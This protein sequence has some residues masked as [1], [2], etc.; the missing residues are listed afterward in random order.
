MTRK[1]LAYTPA[2]WSKIGRKTVFFL[3]NSGDGMGIVKVKTY[4]IGAKNYVNL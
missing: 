2:I 3:V 4:R 1:P